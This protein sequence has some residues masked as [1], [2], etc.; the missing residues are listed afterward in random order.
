MLQLESVSKHFST[1]VLLK[2]ASAH[3]RPGS[4]V[5]LV[6]P[7]GVGKTTL[8]RLILGEQDLDGGRIRKRPRLRIGY[9][10]QDLETIPGKTVLDATHRGHYPEH[11]AKR[12]LSGLGFSESEFNR[13]L[14]TL[15]GGFRM[16][17]ALAH[18]LLSA[19]DVILLDEPTNHLDK[20]TQ[21][22]FEDFL[23]RSPFTILVISHDTKF[24]DRIATH[25]W[26][27]RHHRILESPG[28]Y[29]K[30]LAWR[31]AT[32]AAQTAA[33]NRQ[34]KEIAR[35]QKFV[36]R[37]RY[38]ATKASQVQSRLKQL[39]KVKRIERTRDPKRVRFRFPTPAPSGRHVLD[40]K[41]VAKAYG[42]TVV[43]RSLDFSVERGQRIAL[44]G[45]NGA[46]KS[47]LLK[48]LAGVLPPDKG[49]RLVG[50]GVALHYFAQ[51]QADILNLEHTVLDSIAEAAPRT[52]LNFIR[53]LA[54]AFLFEGAN[55]KKLI[56][57]LSGGERNR[58][59]L[60]RMLVEPANTLLLDEPTNHLDPPSVDVL[61]DALTDFPGTLVFISHD[62]VFLARVATRIV[63][64]EDGQA[65]GYH[66]DYEYYLWKKAQEVGPIKGNP[67]EAA[68][69]VP[70]D[71]PRSQS[72]NKDEAGLPPAMKGPG[73]QRRDLTKALA[74]VE[75]QVSRLEEQIAEGEQRV[76]AR[77]RE[78]AGES[79]Y[80]D[81]ARWNTLNKERAAWVKEQSE[82]TT[83]WA[84]LCEEAEQL[85]GQLKALE[86]PA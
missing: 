70:T 65:R 26:E 84:G 27:I 39:E 19:P 71:A 22:W 2:E 62:P 77:D 54:G 82:L 75:R 1:K 34:D 15:S 57:V 50:H 14:E 43:Y 85:R 37:F 42:E 80:Q 81:H 72:S 17:V 9:L 67:D 63:E 29:T 53:G 41:G 6:G 78:L 51:H 83:Q 48:M 20:A 32:E 86:T 8:L 79:L 36:D 69:A 24:L 55:Q 49:A 16:R 13:P 66:G 4:R 59:A 60:A 31:E 7:N 47:T 38:Q 46:G 5:G 45:E 61:T 28:N 40:L 21:R 56:K 12:I 58:V 64:I 44:V 73:G 33:A 11:E 10:P 23:L 30:Y 35:V 74:R 25:I 3:L 76:Q 52:E 18:L 68:A